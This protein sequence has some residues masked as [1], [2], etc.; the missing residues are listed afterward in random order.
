MQDFIPTIKKDWKLNSNYKLNRILKK[1]K[2]K[3]SVDVL[4][5]ER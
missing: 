2:K 1:K 4:S 3:L 5:Y